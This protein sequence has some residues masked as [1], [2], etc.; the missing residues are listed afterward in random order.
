MRTRQALVAAILL[1]AAIFASC[2]AFAY[3]QGYSVSRALA[4]QNAKD[5]QGLLN[6]ATAWTKAEPNSMDAWG[7]VGNAYV[8]GLHEPDKAIAP[9]RRC[10]TIQPNSAPA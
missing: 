7:L 4:Y 3:G 6:Y 9:L 2:G 8:F 5:W 1:V 10:V